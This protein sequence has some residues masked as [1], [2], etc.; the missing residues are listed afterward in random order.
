MVYQEVNQNTSV[1]NPDA[2]LLAKIDWDVFGT[3]TFREIPPKSVMQKCAAEFVRRVSKKIYNLSTPRNLLYGVRY[4]LG[5]K[6]GRPH[7]H[8]LTGAKRAPE[9]RVNKTTLAKQME[10]IWE[11]EVK[12][13]LKSNAYRPCV[14]FSKIR[15]YDSSKTGAGYICKDALSARDLYELK[16]FHTDITQGFGDDAQRVSLGPKLLLEIAKMRNRSNKVPGFARFLRELKQRNLA[17]KRGGQT[18]TKKY[19]VH[20]SQNWY[21]HPADDEATRLRV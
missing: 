14:G 5:E 3:L 13:T 4:E 12:Q 16:K 6:T 20:P 19:S 11:N 21:Q 18:K 8:F 17:S 7:Y 1:L 10:H 9:T 2:W 15:K